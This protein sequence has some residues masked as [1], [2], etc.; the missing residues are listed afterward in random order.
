MSGFVSE[1]RL[2]SINSFG[3]EM[4]EQILRESSSDNHLRNFYNVV[5][6]HKQKLLLFF[7][8][9]MIAVILGTFL[10]PDVYQSDAKLLVQIGRESINLD[11]TTPQVQPVSIL[12]SREQELNSEMEILVSEELAASVVD[13]LGVERILEGKIPTEKETASPESSPKESTRNS[14]IRKVMNNLVIEVVEASSIIDLEYKA[15]SPRQAS[16]VLSEVIDR[17]LEK[18]FK[19]YRTEGAY[20]FFDQQKDK[21]GKELAETED[22]IREIKT[23]SGIGSVGDQRYFLLERKSLMQR[24][25][26]ETYSGIAASAAKVDVLEKLISVLPERLIT[27]ETTGGALSAADEM[28]KSVN[29]LQLKQNEILTDFTETSIF[30][31]NIR[32]EL[33]GARKLLSEAIDAKTVEKGLN[34][35]RRDLEFIL[36][37]ER[38]LLSS[39]QAKAATLEGQV[40]QV[41]AELQGIIDT[42]DKLNRLEREKELQENNYKKYAEDL[43]QSRIDGVLEQAQISN[44]RVFQEPTM[45]QRPVSPKWMLNLLLGVMVGLLGGL[46]LVLLTDYFD[47]TLKT[48]ED[49]EGRLEIPV[50]GAVPFMEEGVPTKYGESSDLKSQCEILLERLM[51]LIKDQRESQ[52]AFSI[53]SCHNGEGVSTISAYLAGALADRGYGRVLLV[54]TNFEDPLTHQIFSVGNT[55]GLGEMLASGQSLSSFIQPSSVNNL[56]VLCAGQTD[57]PINRH[58]FESKG[59]ADLLAYLKNEY[60][61]ILF[62]T[63]AVWEE[64]HAVI[65]GG[66]LDSVILVVA[67]EETRWEVAHRAKD[68]LTKAGANLLGGILNKR[69]FYVPR[70]LYQSI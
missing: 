17:Y 29:E 20:D 65:L 51:A 22:R 53:T 61:F 49:I 45:P 3:E 43:E 11:E 37:T 56:D 23:K 32:Q 46:G 38:S 52:R 4:Q 25:K 16:D 15:E 31:Q 12:L 59:F 19:I 44:I 69:R 70:R 34:E 54:D 26:E 62:D 64:S 55:P 63:P 40:E 30:A 28:R 2:F 10:M 13:S 33:D 9:V 7:V 67:A 48:P 18:R 14:A 24:N 60:T 58:I 42:E 27:R 68:R 66:L 41:E 50:L 39:L 35:M 21:L 8:C 5:F 6:R 1:P 36:A 57:E 47:H